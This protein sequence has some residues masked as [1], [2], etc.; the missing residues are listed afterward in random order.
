MKLL[1]SGTLSQGGSITVS[2]FAYYNVFYI[3]LKGTD[4]GLLAIRVGGPGGTRLQGGSTGTYIA[5]EQV[6]DFV[7][8]G[9]FVGTKLT[10]NEAGYWAE[11]ASAGYPWWTNSGVEAIYGV[12]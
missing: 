7:F 6:Y 12:L 2:E 4:N 5:G 1:W 10:L 3:K 11:T 9:K 8:S